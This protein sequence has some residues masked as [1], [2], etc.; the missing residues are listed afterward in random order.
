MPTI[1]LT[2]YVVGKT[3]DWF[4]TADYFKPHLLK[5]F[6]SDDSVTLVGPLRARVSIQAHNRFTLIGTASQA[7]QVKDV[8]GYTLDIPP[9]QSWTY[10]SPELVA[11]LGANAGFGVRI[12]PAGPD[13]CADPCAPDPCAPPGPCAPKRKDCHCGSSPCHCHATGDDIPCDF[14]VANLPNVGVFF[15]AACEPCTP[16]AVVA[17]PPVKGPALVVRPAGG[18]TVRTRYFNGMFITRED[19][20]TDQKN[21]RLKRSLMNRAL[22][23]GVVWGFNVG[24]D[25]EAICVLPGYGVDCCGNDIVLTSPYRVD[26]SA[27][28]RDPAAA[29]LLSMPGPHRLH[30]L[31]EYFE[32]PEQPRPVHGDVCAP[33][34][35]RCETSRIRETA[36]LRLVPP[37][38]V[39]DSGP[40]KDFL[41]EVAQLRR[42]PVV[43]RFFET[44]AVCGAGAA[45]PAM[46]PFDVKVETLALIRTGPAEVPVHFDDATLAPPVA[47]PTV[48]DD[49]AIPFSITPPVGQ[50]DGLLRITVTARTGFQFLAGAPVR[51]L[52]FDVATQTSSPDSTAITPTTSTPTEI[53]WEQRLHRGVLTLA[54][55]GTTDPIP[56]AYAYQLQGWRSRDTAGTEFS[57]VTEI[58]LTPLD[59]EAWGQTPWGRDHGGNLPA[60]TRFVLHAAVPA[61]V[62][63]GPFPCASEACDPEGR[64]RFPVAPPWLHEDPT[65]PGTAADPK[66]LVLAVL[67]AW[68]ASE[69]A[70]T[71]VGT[72]QEVR[73]AQLDTALALSRA[74]WRRFFATVPDTERYQL[75]DAL[76][77]LFQAWCKALL[78]PG[79]KCLCDPHGVVIGCVL[80]DGGEIRMVDPWGGRRW[81]VHYP[82]L[83]YW[84]QQFGIMP[85][86]AIASKFFDFLCCIAELPAPRFPVRQGGVI[87]DVAG[88]A[89][90]GA[91]PAVG[92]SSMVNL[93]RAL[94][95]FDTA[96]GAERRLSSL[97]L[98][99]ERSVA[100]NP[101]DFVGRV[102][103]IL[104]AP[105]AAPA[106]QPLVRYT[107]VGVPDLHFFTPGEAAPA[108][109]PPPADVRGG[110]LRELV[111][112][113]FA[114]RPARAAVPALLRELGEEVT[115]SLVASAPLEAPDEATRP[116]VERL[117]AAGVSTVGAVLGRHPE[118]LHVEVLGRANPA[119][120]TQLLDEAERITRST[121]KVVGDTLVSFAAE[122]HL[123]ARDALADP[124]ITAE[125]S[126]LLGEKLAAARRPANPEVIQ[127]AVA[128]ATRG[129]R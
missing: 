21:V 39:D 46:I 69:M 1:D 83:A 34:T 45:A 88:S 79:P 7:E 90:T 11:G 57:G 95:M 113:A 61:P 122:R 25:G 121:A 37:C 76:Q 126:A 109:A 28:L 81:V 49:V 31:L 125:F 8:F 58:D 63:R 120:L 65:E 6:A 60:N 82:L 36:R 104:S 53:V 42:D 77:R 85:L 101:F 78:Y 117:A 115:R 123:A 99:A 2:A 108:P 124:V 4:K 91:E 52:R 129:A 112:A 44:P 30:L 94:L 17:L 92:R 74:V 66:V 86:D 68:L 48:R 3:G 55:P 24:R 87:T 75:T 64:P 67:Y 10:R 106:N 111:R 23:Q 103:E 105:T 102:S 12:E 116:V 71:K 13:V 50:P 110:R 32:C 15:P 119:E 38:D 33:D 16:G 20:E 93:G 9:G 26:G 14:A 19:L 72:P 100:L 35:T 40:I 51:T 43:G 97:G 27:L 114:A 70:R 41:E 107:A 47:P 128:E 89:G 56:P 29:H 127:A 96:A 18:G 118:S 98:R 73:S 80:V 59:R 62:G 22:G 5:L 54:N 84:G